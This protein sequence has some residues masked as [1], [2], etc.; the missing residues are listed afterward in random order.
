MGGGNCQA[1]AI[2]MAARP[3]KRAQ[4]SRPCQ[5]RPQRSGGDRRSPAGEREPH[6]VRLARLASAGAVDQSNPPNPSA[7][8]TAP[9][10]PSDSVFVPSLPRPVGWQVQRLA[11]L[12]A[13]STQQ[14]HPRSIPRPFRRR[15]P[16]TCAAVR[17]GEISHDVGLYGCVKKKGIGVP[18]GI[19]IRVGAS[20]GP[21]DRPLHYRDDQ[22][23][24]SIF[25]I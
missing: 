15:P 3:L 4:V 7:A 25:T 10:D 14:T 20:T 17:A 23:V 8:R 2:P 1:L 11:A 12:L 13:R 5:A 22:S 6:M 9:R 21:H 19:R 24:V 18:D 16:C